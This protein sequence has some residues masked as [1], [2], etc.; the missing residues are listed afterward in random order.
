MFNKKISVTLIVLLFFASSV[1]EVFAEEIVVYSA[2]SKSLTRI[3]FSKFQFQTGINIKLVEGNIDELLEKLKKEGKTSPADV[4]IT[5]DA[6]SLWS[7]TQDGLFQPINSDTLTKNIPPHLRDPGNH[8]FGLSK[9]AR[10]IVYSKLKVRASELSTYE[11]L[12]DQKWANKLCLRTSQKVYNQSLVAM[13]ITKHGI[14]GTEEIIKGWVQNLAEPPYKKDTDVITALKEKKCAVGI[15]NHYYLGKMLKADPKMPVGL[16]WPNQGENE[17]GVFVDISGA[18]VLKNAKNKEL[19]IKFL[20]WLSSEKA[21]S[22]FADSNLE[23][24]VNQNVKPNSLV[25]AWGDFE[26]YTE[27]L[28]QSGENRREAIELMKRAKYQ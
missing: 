23:Y 16:F 4:L 20:N 10:T 1:F 8:W 17:G 11:D 9:R 27:N 3:P 24:P 2:R 14:E 22:L 13:M 7:A 18:G 26:Q 6:G 25:Q 12:A 21:Q 28:G 15:V 19:A 5:V